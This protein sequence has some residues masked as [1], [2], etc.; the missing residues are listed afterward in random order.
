MFSYSVVISGGFLFFLFLL[1]HSMPFHSI[2]FLIPTIRSSFRIEM[3]TI[4]LLLCTAAQKELPSS[5]FGNSTE[6]IQMTIRRRQGRR[7]IE[8][9][10]WENWV[11]YNGVRHM[12]NKLC[13]EMYV[14][15]F[16]NMIEWVKG[17]SR[18]Y[19]VRIALS[20]TSDS[21]S[22]REKSNIILMVFHIWETI[23]L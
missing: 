6:D 22:Y 19:V 15:S 20:G 8:I 4:L 5:F 10:V 1:F 9:M 18:M 14:V 3:Y 2:P 13:S 11:C 21:R 17:E 16:Y 23:A 12:K 7:C